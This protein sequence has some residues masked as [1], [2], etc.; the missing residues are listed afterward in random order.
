MS[1][2]LGA[3]KTLPSAGAQANS[4]P[5]QQAWSPY[6]LNGGTSMAIS[7]KDF[8]IVAGDTRMSDGYS[9]CSRNV[10][11]IK[12]LTPSCVLTTAG[13]QAERETLN[14]VLHHK[15]TMYEHRHNKEMS[16]PSI[17]Q[18]LSTTLYHKR[19]FPYY[20]F[21]VL[22]GL[23]QDGRGA[24]WGYDAVGSFE[25]VPY[26]VTGTGSAMITSLLDNQVAF[27]TQPQ[28]KRDLS[29]EETL[30]LVKDCLTCCT[31]R[32]IYTG[33]SADIAIIT[34]DGVKVQKF[35]LKKD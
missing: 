17:A 28:N 4:A 34:K 24:V 1:V 31:E 15:I 13:M 8:C 21:N 30:E 11:K 2:A 16:A 23:D 22:G 5:R 20:T 32:D 35:E 18:M 9:I 3:M 27:K 14:K 6:N 25:R 19:F 10:S 33:D 7:G 12:E 26:C 29:L